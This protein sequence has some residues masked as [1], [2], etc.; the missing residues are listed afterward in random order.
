MFATGVG[1]LATGVGCLATGVGCLATGVGCLF[2]L[3]CFVYSFTYFKSRTVKNYYIKCFFN[4]STVHWCEFLENGILTFSFKPHEFR[5]VD[6][7]KIS[8]TATEI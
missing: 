1:C 4:I 8:F 7:L 3:F 6:F 2:I 5:K